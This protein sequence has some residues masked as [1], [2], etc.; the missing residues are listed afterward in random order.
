MSFLKKIVAIGFEVHE[1]PK[2]ASVTP[3]TQAAPGASVTHIPVSLPQVV[4]EDPKVREFL[5][6]LL[7]AKNLPGYDYL[8]HVATEENLLQAL[9]DKVTRVRAALAMAKTMGATKESILGSIEVYLKHLEEQASAF[10]LDNSEKI[11]SAL[12]KEQG[13]LN[14]D[15]Q[16]NVL[17]K[18]IEELKAKKT[19]ELTRIELEKQE[20]YKVRDSFV[21]TYGK[22]KEK[23]DQDKVAIQAA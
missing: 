17:Q 16:I 6:N 11:K 15:E 19:E 5:Q 1:D 9:P 18:Q 8:E 10:S 13:L 2:A 20:L 21:Q 7:S 22:F 23:I 12:A 3:V 4:S 14:Y